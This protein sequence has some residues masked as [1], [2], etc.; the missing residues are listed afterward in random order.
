MPKQ[1]ILSKSTASNNRKQILLSTKQ[2][3][4]LGFLLLISFYIPLISIPIV[5]SVI[6][7]SLARFEKFSLVECLILSL[8]LLF[9]CNILL[10][11]FIT[12]LHLHLTT[13]YAFPIITVAITGLYLLRN[14]NAITVPKWPRR[15]KSDIAAGVVGLVTFCLL[16]VP[17]FN[18]NA[19]TITHFM[20]YGEDNA[21]HY[22]L[23][24]Y[25]FSHGSFTY[26]ETGDEAGVVASLEIYPQGFHVNAASA[27]SL[28]SPFHIS[29][30]IF[31]KVY[32]IFISIMYALFAFWLTKLCMIGTEKISWTVIIGALPGVAFLGSLSFF[33]L[34]LDRGFQPQI[35][36]FI[37]LF[38]ITYSLIVLNKDSGR[39]WDTLLLILTL[40]IGIS[41]SWW[42][43]LVI[44]FVLLLFYVFKNGYF[45][46]LLKNMPSR[47]PYLLVALFGIL[48]PIL[49]N[50]VLS[51]KQDPISEPGG[52]DALPGYL[53][54]SLLIVCV[55]TLPAFVRIKNKNIEYMYIALA[56]STGLA[57]LIGAYHLIKLGHFE[58]YFYKVGYVIIAFLIVIASIGV[59]HGSKALSSKI[60]HK[61]K[62]LVPSLF[63]LV[64][65]FFA[66]ATN[67][68]FIKVYVNHWLPS[69]VEVV[70][71]PILFTEKT[72]YYKD[73]L[74]VGDCSGPSD[75]LSNRWAGARLLSDSA[76]RGEL[77]IDILNERHSD[78]NKDLTSYLSS[79]TYPILLSVDNR[80]ADKLPILKT[81]SDLNHVDVIY[82]H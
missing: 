25:V 12:F 10:Y 53:F 80:C 27:A 43:L 31:I 36:S 67:L 30:S 15:T 9:A 61:Y 65:V 22:A 82:T 52:V 74:Y 57:T 14:K 64:A 34:M 51:K 81:I 4:C 50:I 26:N 23:S 79:H 39:M 76:V 55:I 63:L 6:V 7:F 58:Y 56:A 20:S 41:A 28:L 72:D 46:L 1:T 78:V 17:I 29:E 11:S 68:V 19:S 75:Y 70:D 47:I 73:I 42:F 18:Q 32:I 49:V 24:R 66:F 8:V 16:L 48:Y 40:S 59:L 69:S 44:V 3:V 62:L 77:I 13:R 33:I 2:L 38:A 45:K 54:L 5:I 35:F 60:P 21:S 37:Y 71:T